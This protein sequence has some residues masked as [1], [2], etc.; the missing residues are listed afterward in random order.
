MPKPYIP[1]DK[2]SQR[3]AAEGYRARSVYK[4]QELDERFQLLRPGAHILDIGAAPGSWLQYASKR[5]GPQGKILGLDLTPI[6]P[7]SENVTTKVC[8][9][10]KDQE[11]SEAL[12][13]EGFDKV[14]VVLSDIAPNTSGIHDRDQWLSIELSRRV[15]VI[16]APVLKRNGKLV[17]KVFRGRDFDSFLREI[18]QTYPHAK[19][20]SVAASRDRSKEVYI[21]VDR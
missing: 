18:K 6:E 16:A 14:D 19:P 17:M 1:N 20:V 5:V 9:I 2:W 10:L 12:Q 21:V 4:L 11:V 3:A 7:V 15:I 13:L 8:D